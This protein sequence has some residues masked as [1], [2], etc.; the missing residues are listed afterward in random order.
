MEFENTLKKTVN[1]ERTKIEQ[2]LKAQFQSQHL[3]DDE[4][5]TYKSEHEKQMALLEEKHTQQ[6]DQLQLVRDR[7]K[8]K[9]EELNSSKTQYLSNLDSIKSKFNDEIVN[10]KAELDEKSNKITL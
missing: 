7:L 3:H 4:M 8:K 6:C 1:Q 5:F 2:E 10:L 9:E